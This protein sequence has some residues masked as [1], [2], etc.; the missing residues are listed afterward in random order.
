MNLY[1]QHISVFI[2]NPWEEAKWIEV[3]KEKRWKPIHVVNYTPDG[4]L[5]ADPRQF[6][7]SKYCHR[8]NSQSAID[9]VKSLSSEIRDMGFKVVRTKVE[10]MLANREFDTLNIKGKEGVYWEFHAKVCNSFEGL[11]SL[12]KK[13]VQE[14]KLYRDH[15]AISM[16]MYSSVKPLIVTIRVNEGTRDEALRIKNYIL[17]DLKKEGFHIEGKIQSE[18]S[19]YDDCSRQDFGWFASHSKL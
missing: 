4:C 3:C 16:S 5:S 7:M 19:I 15:V 6:M 9:S 14:D 13:K 12:Y 18:V 8:D 1:E 11:M 17:D 2:S 10:G